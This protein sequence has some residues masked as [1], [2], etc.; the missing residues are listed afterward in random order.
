MG[1]AQE[2]MA[3]LEQDTPAEPE[4]R[5]AKKRSIWRMYCWAL[6]SSLCSGSL[7]AIGRF[8]PGDPLNS[9]VTWIGI[10]G[11]IA[12]L[13]QSAW[14]EISRWRFRAG[15]EPYFEAVRNRACMGHG[16]PA[17]F[18]DY[19]KWCRAQGWRFWWKVLRKN[20]RV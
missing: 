8:G 4:A 7:I 16:D 12:N 14:F 10:A 13:I 9:V 20:H 17:T 15:L 5:R 6:L 11:L 2:N 19:R 1:N 3:A 18:R